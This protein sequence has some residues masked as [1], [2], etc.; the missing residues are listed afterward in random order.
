MRRLSIAALA[1]AATAFSGLLPA[2][3]ADPYQGPRYRDRYH[4]RY[5][6]GPYPEPT[7]APAPA[8]YLGPV[9]WSP[10]WPPCPPDTVAAIS[11]QCIPWRLHRGAKCPQP[12]MWVVDGLCRPYSQRW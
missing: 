8:P 10:V 1:L 7:I 4:D 3:A 6:R 12:N 11:G 2:S 9:Y 5:D